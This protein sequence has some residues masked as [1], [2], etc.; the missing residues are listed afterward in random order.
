MRTL[1]RLSR[2]PA[3]ALLLS[4]AIF[5]AE[6]THAQAAPGQLVISELRWQGPSGVLDEFVELYNASG[7][8]HTVTAVDGSAGY[9]VVA[10]DGLVRCV[11]PN[12]TLIPARGHFLC[13][14]NTPNLGYS[15]GSYP[16]GNGTTATGDAFFIL[17]IPEPD[18]DA[19]GPQPAY[20]AGVALFRTTLPVNF[21]HA[22]RLDAVG[23]QGEP[24][25]LFREG[26][27]L[28]NL[29]GHPLNYSWYRDL[30]AVWPKDTG[31]NAADFL[32]V[33]PDGA[34]DGAGRRLGAPGP[35]NLSSPRATPAPEVAG[36][37]FA[38]CLD[39]SQAPNRE[40]FFDPYT[41]TLTPTT[42]YDLGTL[43]IRRRLVNHT[44]RPL[45][46]LRFRV[47]TLTTFPSTTTTDLRLLTAPDQIISD[48]CT[49]ALR[50]VK[51]M[52]LEQGTAVAQ[53]NGGGF[54]S[55]VSVDS[56]TPMNP[57]PAFDDP[58]TPQQ[59]N[60][61]DVQ[62]LLGVTGVENGFRFFGVVEAL[63]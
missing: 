31:D 8:A 10:S 61:L 26:A 62:Y 22:N 41:D 25:A 42:T 1:I 58:A 48:P 11:I 16:A 35:E 23:S 52:K 13:V 46:R 9:S 54:N 5:D 63:P 17:D 49:G 21:T 2:A 39:R 37:L 44:G 4:I 40:R 59:E 43:A 20:Q 19:D 47:I 50:E 27:G 60:A 24:N 12:G 15:L 6:V 57:L 36:D 53:P 51:G 3:A 34:D 14:N 55:T 45:T 28:P 33:S 56:V 32:F 38:P 18:P 30:S 7:A 29:A